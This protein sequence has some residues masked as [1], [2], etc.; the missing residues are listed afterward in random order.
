MLSNIFQS[1]PCIELYNPSS[2]DNIKLWKMRGKIIKEFEPYSKSYIHIL[3]LGGISIMSIPSQEKHLLQIQN[4]FLLFQFFLI[5]HKSF[6]I[7][8][9]VRDINNN[10]K[11]MKIPINNY[12]LNIWTNLLIDVNALFQQ[13]Y[14]N[15][16]KYIDTLLITGNI[17]IRRIY[18][19][20]TKQEELPK[21]L[22]LGKFITVQNYFLFD[23]NLDCA[24]I[25]IKI[26]ENGYRKENTTPIKKGRQISPLRIDNKTNDINLITKKN[27]KFAKKI[28]DLTRLKNEINYGLVIKQNGMGSIINI[29]KILGFNALENLETFNNIKTPIKMANKNRENS[30]RKNQKSFEKYNYK[31]LNLKRKKIKSINPINRN[32]YNNLEQ[33]KYQLNERIDIHNNNINNNENKSY[34]QNDVETA[35]NNIN[36][37][38]FH[39]DTLYNFGNKNKRNKPKYIS[40][41]IA[42]QSSSKKNLPNL[43]DNNELI[44]PKL[45]KNNLQLPLIKSIIP[46]QNINGVE[47]NKNNKYGNFEIMLDSA[48]VNNSRVQAQLYD[49]IEED[50]CLINN[51]INST[52]IEGT[53]LEDKIIKIEPENNKLNLFDKKNIKNEFNVTNSDFPDISNLINDD[54]DNSNR[55]YTPPLAKLVPLNQSRNIGQ[56][57]IFGDE[58]NISHNN[59]KNPNN[60]SYV[61]VIKDSENLIYDE[62]K[63]CYYN[64][65]TNVYYDI[66]NHF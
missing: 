14:Q 23:Y 4:T 28:P 48:L 6:N 24:K 39:N 35:I 54:T 15:S 65:K 41:G 20:K 60:I 47:N 8:L 18:A 46:K 61:K 64:P 19:M 62:I 58:K 51:N 32:K 30:S 66:K 45:E 37:I 55:P 53:K 34:Q 36:K 57:N 52:L 21:S 42:E 31:D 1:G 33:K 17:K 38:V 50:S 13:T 3:L 40:Y 63:G 49:S 2:N 5:N 56:N 10:K 29:N 7:E 25:N 26:S 59:R 9:N 44:L 27:I 11:K 16:L 22:D 12:P 43:K